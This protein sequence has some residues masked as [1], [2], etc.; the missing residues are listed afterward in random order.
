M[1][2]GLNLP[3]ASALTNRVQRTTTRNWA[4]R[5]ESDQTTID[6]DQIVFPDLNVRWSPRGPLFGGL[7]KS[8]GM[9]GRLLHTRQIARRA[10][11]VGRR[12]AGRARDARAHLSA[13][14]VADL[15]AGRSDDHGGVFL[16]HAGGFAARERRERQRRRKRAPRSDARSGYLLIG[17]SR[18]G[19]ARDSASSKA[20]PRATLRIC[21]R[22]RVAVVSPTT[23]GRRSRSTPIPTSRTTL[24]SAFKA[25]AS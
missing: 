25:L 5:L 9:N 8:A 22:R 4:R 7:V 12:G 15:G 17:V 1:S 23:A 24:P 18:A 13:Q 14:R 6:G 19:S 21:S 10:R 11:R 20:G 16:S 3:L 2:S